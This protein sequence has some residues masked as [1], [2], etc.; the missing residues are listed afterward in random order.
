MKHNAITLKTI[1]T[2]LGLSCP[3]GH[4]DL[5]ITGVATLEEAGPG[6]ISFLANPKYGAQAKASNASAIFIKAGAA[7]ETGAIQ[8]QCEDPYVTF[9]FHLTHLERQFSTIKDEREQ[10][11]IHPTAQ[12]HPTAIISATAIVGANVQIGAHSKIG[13]GTKI[14]AG[15]LLGEHVTVESGAV[16][17]SQGFGFAP[18]KNGVYHTIPQLGKVVLEDHVFVGAN[19]TVDRGAIG[20][21]RIGT[22]TKIDNLCMIAHNVKVGKHTVIAA[23]TGIAGSTTVGD[24]CMIGGQ[25]GII[26][27][28]KIGNGVKIYAQTG[29][30]NDVPDNKVIFGSPALERRHFLKSFA[31]FKKQGE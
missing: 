18:D 29:V 5:E 9:A 14:L 12:I 16:I 28:L 17:G 19:S 31:A 20:E 8:L 22:G 6:D 25:V 3:Q 21:T 13:Q 26:G 4:E 11:E 24:H 10:A 23:Q 30:M 27:H 15:S 7:I 1:C 2:Q